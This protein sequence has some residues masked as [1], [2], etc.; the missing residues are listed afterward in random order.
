MFS[1]YINDLPCRIKYGRI[2]LFADDGK[3]VAIF[4]DKQH[5]DLFQEDMSSVGDWSDENHLPLSMDK[6][7]TLHYGSK[8]PCLSYQINRVAICDCME[9]ADLRVLRTSDFR[10]NKH[11]DG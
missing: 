8:N 5:H 6:C 9:C 10:Y 11:I 2:F 7:A 3:A 1:A 4:D